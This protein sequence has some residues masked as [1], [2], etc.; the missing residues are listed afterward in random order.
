MNWQSLAVRRAL[1]LRDVRAQ[2]GLHAAGG[3][4]AD[5]RHR[6]QHGD[7]H[8]RERR[9]ARS[10]CPT[11]S[12]DGS[13]MVWS[14]N[15][16]EHRDHESWRRCDFLDFRKAGAFSELHATYS[17]LVGATLTSSAGAEQI[18]VSVRHARHVRDAGPARR[19]SAGRS[20]SR[21]RATAVIVSHAV[22]AVEARRRPERPRPRAQHPDQPRTDRRRHAARLRVPLQDD[23]RSERLHAGRLRSRRGC[24]SQFVHQRQP[25]RP[26]RAT[27]TRAARFLS[28]VGRLKPGV[29]VGAGGGGDRRHRAAARGEAI[30]TS[31]RVVGA[32]V[33]PL[34]EQAVGSMRPA[35]MLL[36][37]GV[38]FVLL[39]AC[40]NLAN[41]LLARSSVRQREMAIR[42]ALG[43]ARRRLIVQTMVETMLLSLR[44]RHRWRSVTVNWA[45]ARS[46][47]LAP[48]G[49]AAASARVRPE[50]L[51]CWCFTFALSLV[52]GTRD[53]PRAGPGGVAAARCSRP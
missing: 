29:T 35:L 5:A 31:N 33:V 38:G 53:R 10:R 34:H 15:A 37:G 46:L 24:R 50:R 22:L 47:A 17:F 30:P 2:P 36:L 7:L 3:R 41:L 43:A 51:R 6:R 14:T 44:R 28:V 52:T 13:V 19:F 39:M 42:S 1:R 8:H 21:R 11:A 48:A 4:R 9:A 26:A 49:H 16:I 25:R 32:T 45:S 23:A 20:P 27:L 40:V 12:P 18:L